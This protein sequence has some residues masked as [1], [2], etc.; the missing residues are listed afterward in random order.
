MKKLLSIFLTLT[1]IL[2]SAI[3]LSAPASVEAASK[4]SKVINKL[5]KNNWYSYKMYRDGEPSSPGSSVVLG[6]NYLRFKKNKKFE[7][8]AGLEG[9]SGKYTVSKKGK[10]TLHLKKQWNGTGFIKVRKKTSKVKLFKSYKRLSFSVRDSDSTI[11][12]Y[13][14]KA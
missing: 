11:K 1:M 12:Y 6:G 7:Y 9:A 4:R 8:N 10:V 5:V 13:F 2:S 3:V 14:K